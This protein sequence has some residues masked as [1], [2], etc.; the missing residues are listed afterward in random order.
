MKYLRLTHLFIAAGLTYF[1]LHITLDSVPE[2]FVLRELAYHAGS[3]VVVSAKQEENSKIAMVFHQPTED[4]SGAI[5]KQYT[6]NGTLKNTL[7]LPP[8]ILQTPSGETFK[9]AR[10]PG[11]LTHPDDGSY[12]IWFPQLGTEVYFF[13]S[14]GTFLWEKKESRYLQA[15]PEGRYILAAAGDHSRLMVLNPSLQPLADFEG[16][17]FTHFR[18]SD[19]EE[20]NWQ[21]CA[22][23]ID[24]EIVAAALEKKE[25]YRLS[26]PWPVKSLECDFNTGKFWA[27]VEII[28]ET[29][30]RHD[31]LIQADLPATHGETKIKNMTVLYRAFRSWPLSWPLA[32]SQEGDVALLLPAEDN[33]YAEKIIVLHGDKVFM[34]DIPTN[35]VEIADIRLNAARNGFIMTTNN[36]MITFDRHGITGWYARNN[37]HDLRQSKSKNYFYLAADESLSVFTLSDE[38]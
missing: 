34:R 31:Q 4:A 25:Q 12:F 10:K 13:D 19:N 8:Q 9:R 5:I 20:K 23:F 22:S 27:Q 30:G 37:L 38:P 16:L 3:A 29:H 14:N 2:R 26:L 6:L 35:A 33:R 7:V 32:V 17:I 24:G 15:S 36:G 21:F 28:D 11:F 1:S 18:L